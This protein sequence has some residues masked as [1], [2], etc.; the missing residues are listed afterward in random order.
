MLK[1]KNIVIT[2]ASSGIGKELCNSLASEN[3]IIAI[4]R[5]ISNIP[6]HKNIKKYSCDFSN[7]KNIDDLFVFINQHFEI[8][9]I[10]FA[11]AGFAYFE[12]IKSADWKHIESIFNTNTFSVFYS[13][14]KLK[15]LQKNK[16]FNFVITASAMSFMAIPGYSLYAATKFALK[17][18]ADAYR[19]E[20]NKNQILSL[21]YP[22]ATYTNFFDVA[23]SD[24]M[25]WPRQKASTVAKSI[26]KGVSKNSTNIYPSF[27]FRIG[28]FLNRFFPF[29]SSYQKIEGGKFRKKLNKL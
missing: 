6:E 8:I 16:K 10:F 13:L 12:E 11:N 15:E 26:I 4:S 29:Y 23:H 1:N 17:G 27:L 22:V 21:V 20:L 7:S 25:P 3:K 14:F 2:G 19:Y 9:D 18:F 28:M 24:K 5:N